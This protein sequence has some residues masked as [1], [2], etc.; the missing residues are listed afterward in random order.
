MLVTATAKRLH[1]KNDLKISINEHLI[2]FVNSCKYLGV[3]LDPC[4]NMKEHLQKTLKSA[5][6]RIKL[7]KRIRQSLTSH[8]AESIY[9]AIAL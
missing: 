2:H 4:L 3:I 7:L 5:A 9:K 6:V 1:S 8:A